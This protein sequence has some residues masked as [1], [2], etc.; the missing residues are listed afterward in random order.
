MWWYLIAYNVQILQDMVSK[1]LC[2]LILNCLSKSLPIYLMGLFFCVWTDYLLTLNH[3]AYF[4]DSGPLLLLS[5][6]LACQPMLPSSETKGLPSFKMQVQ[7]FLFCSALSKLCRR[8]FPPSLWVYLEHLS[9]RTII[10]WCIL[11]STS[12]VI[13]PRK[14]HVQPL[15]RSKRLVNS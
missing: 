7:C 8:I 11:F 15:E 14:E 9:Y 1:Y 2:I 13:V 10:C 3:I 4:P 12:K 6:C 5:P